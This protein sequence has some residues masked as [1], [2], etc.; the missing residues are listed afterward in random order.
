M[1]TSQLVLVKRRLT[2]NFTQIPNSMIRD[3]SI[4]SKSLGILVHLL[5]LPAKDFHVSLEGVCRARNEGEASI[6]SAIKQLESQGYMKIVRE[7]SST[8]RYVRS[9]WLVSDTPIMD[10]APYLENPAVDNLAVEE[11]VVEKKGTTNTVFVETLN[12]ITT[13]TEQ[14]PLSTMISPVEIGDDSDKEIWSWLCEKISIDPQ[15]ARRKCV[16]LS[17]EVALD[18]LAEV[19]AIQRQ[20]GIKKSVSQ[21]MSAL[22]RKAHEGKFNLSAGAE[23]RKEIPMILRR[24]RELQAVSRAAIATPPQETSGSAISP[25]EVLQLLR[26]GLS[27]RTAISKSFRG[28]K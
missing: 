13:T 14:P 24:Q 8:G 1:Y 5:S 27:K 16:G 4:G 12:S 9:R 2:G 6:R 3:K 19:Y 7:R 23:I 21:F 18:I 15:Q 25:D 22:L 28:E 10:W 20:N 11:P 17:T 26:A